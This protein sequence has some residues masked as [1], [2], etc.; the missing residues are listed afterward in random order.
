MKR[1]LAIVGIVGLSIFTSTSI[2]SINISC[3]GIDDNG[4]QIQLNAYEPYDRNVDMI[5]VIHEQFNY[6]YN[7]T[8]ELSFNPRPG[9]SMSIEG[10]GLKFTMK[11]RQPGESFHRAEVSADHTTKTYTLTCSAY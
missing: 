8:G 1:I 2:A 9:L 11:D 3:S 4:N 10:R 6:V 5:V 7:Y